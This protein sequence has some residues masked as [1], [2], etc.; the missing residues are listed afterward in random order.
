MVPIV[1]IDGPSGSGKGTIAKALALKLAWNYLDSGLLYR[2][3]AFLHNQNTDNISEAFSR[4]EHKYDF[5]SENISTCISHLR[6]SWHSY[7]YIWLI[8]L[9]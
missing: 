9:L 2:C 3:F 4:L 6:P 7:Y 1:T 8:L 5:Q